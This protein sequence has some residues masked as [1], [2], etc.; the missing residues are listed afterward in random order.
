M[1][2]LITQV[3][4]PVNALMLL[5]IWWRLEKYNGRLNRVE[6]ILINQDNA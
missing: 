5:V 6:N 2:D 3:T 1:I 4:D